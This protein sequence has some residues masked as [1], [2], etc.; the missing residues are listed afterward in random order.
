[1]TVDNTDGV[2][3]GDTALVETFDKSGDE[4]AVGDYYYVSYDY[5]KND[6][7]AD[8]YFRFRRVEEEF[9][10]LSPENT[11]TLASYLAFI[12][13]AVAV[14][15]KQLLTQPGSNEASTQD[16]LTALEDLEKPLDNNVTPD[17]IVP[18][19]TDST[20][21]QSTV[22]HCEVQSSPRHRQERRCILGMA[23][24]SQPS[25][26]RELAKGLESERAI[27]LYPDSAI[28]T[29]ENELGQ[30]E[31]HIVDGTFLAA[32]LAGHRADPTL[33]V[34][35]PITRKELSGFV[36]LNRNLSNIQKNQLA[37][38]GVTVLED[39]PGAIRVRD[40]LTTDLS[41][42]LTKNPSV[43]AIKDFVNQRT[44]AVLDSFIGDKFLGSKTQDIEFAVKQLLNSLQEADIISGSTGVRA[45][46]DPDDS[47]QIRVRAFFSPVFP[48]KYVKV[49]FVVQGD[50]QS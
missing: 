44:R 21:Q 39:V 30:S 22:Q 2:P 16:Y 24:G 45:I 19:T 33:D 11:L 10:S 5:Q 29:L 15:C 14:G 17:L 20:V 42:E 12:N 41:G 48:L 4:P 7:E 25:D 34:A 37:T 28:I 47:T 32:A 9:G 35:E 50:Q 8:T 36:R 18:L 13:G 23:S 6:F 43:V 3:S 26:A 27:L 31:Q 40:G 38:A 46:P 49:T 1:M